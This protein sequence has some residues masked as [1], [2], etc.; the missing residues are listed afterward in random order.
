[1]PSLR[2]IS[3][4][5]L[6]LLVAAMPRGPAFAELKPKIEITPQIPHA[7]GIL[8]VAVSKDLRLP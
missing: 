4:A 5:I 8:S 1:M 2:S 7:H 3:S 6:A